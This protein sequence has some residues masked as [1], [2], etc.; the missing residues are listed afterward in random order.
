MHSGK[1]F[2]ALNTIFINGVGAGKYNMTFNL[3]DCSIRVSQY[4]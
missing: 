4:T 1:V 3:V 2:Q